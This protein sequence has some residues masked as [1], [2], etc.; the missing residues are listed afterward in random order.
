MTE[1]NSFAYKLFLSLDITDSNLFFIKKLEPAPW[2]KSPFSKSWGPVKP[3]LFGNLVGGSSP[4]AERGRKGCT[5]CSRSFLIFFYLAF[6]SVDFIDIVF[7]FSSRVNISFQLWI[8]KV[9]FLNLKKL[10]LY[11]FNT[12][13]LFHELQ[14]CSYAGKYCY[15]CAYSSGININK[16]APHLFQP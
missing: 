15:I 10:L 14:L 7:N 11:S 5:L 16:K 1:K 13:F 8:Y 6:N 4:P 2:K 9:I 3:S 12:C